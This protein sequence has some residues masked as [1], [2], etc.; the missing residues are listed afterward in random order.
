LRNL[1]LVKK[2][3]RKNDVCTG[4]LLIIHDLIWMYR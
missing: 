1:I 2:K 3:R 4:K